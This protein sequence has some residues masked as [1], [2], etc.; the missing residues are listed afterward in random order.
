MRVFARFFA[1]RSLG[2]VAWG[3]QLCSFDFQ[4]EDPRRRAPLPR[5][6]VGPLFSEAP[7]PAL[8]R[9]ARRRC[10]R[11]GRGLL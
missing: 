2:L 11:W 8:G 4:D 10:R 6:F 3:L 1:F 7:A 9:S 5:L